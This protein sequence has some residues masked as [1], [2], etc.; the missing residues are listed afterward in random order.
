MIHVVV[1]VVTLQDDDDAITFKLKDFFGTRDAIKFAIS[2]NGTITSKQPL[3]YEAV[4]TFFL[5]VEI[6]DGIPF[7]AVRSQTGVSISVI[8]VNDHTPVFETGDYSASLP[9][10][11]NLNVVEVLQ[12]EASDDD[13]TKKNKR[14]KYT[15]TTGNDEG[16]FQI[17]TNSGSLTVAK[18]LDY[19]EVEFYNLTVQARDTGSPAKYVYDLLYMYICSGCKDFF[20]VRLLGLHAHAAAL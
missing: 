6:S 3:D 14:I 8:D 17:D 19:E 18:A 16:K 4:S 11:V 20:L 7:H 2:D 13:G 5:D 9:E 1:L 15:I 12:V 10:N